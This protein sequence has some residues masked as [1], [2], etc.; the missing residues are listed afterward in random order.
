MSGIAPAFINAFSSSFDTTDDVVGFDFSVAG[1]G[2][3][4]IAGGGGG[5]GGGGSGGPV[6]GAVF[7]STV[8]YRDW[9]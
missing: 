5:G 3:P 6:A 1:G 2:G 7:V 4:P 8:F 9:F